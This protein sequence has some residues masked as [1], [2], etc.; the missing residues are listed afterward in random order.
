VDTIQTEPAGYPSIR[1]HDETDA[2]HV[3]CTGPDVFPYSSVSFMDAGDP[4]PSRAPFARP[5]PTPRAARRPRGA[6]GSR[7]PRSGGAATTAA[8]GP[9]RSKGRPRPRVGSR[10]G[11]SG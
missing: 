2:M 10:G 4:I 3:F 6:P 11:R 7:P 9:P 8:R 1:V 5:G